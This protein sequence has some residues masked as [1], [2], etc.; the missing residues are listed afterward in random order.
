VPAFGVGVDL[1]VQARSSGQFPR[2]SGVGNVKASTC[3]ASSASGGP[4]VVTLRPGP[5][6]AAETTSIS[7][8]WRTIRRV[9]CRTSIW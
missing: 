6:K 8:A 9:G 5:R 3:R 2:G 7:S 4:S 1:P